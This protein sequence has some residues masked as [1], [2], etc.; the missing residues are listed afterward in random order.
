MLFLRVLGKTLLFIAFLALAYD[1]AR[2]LATPSRGVSLTSLSTH[3]NTYLPGA[4]EGLERFLHGHSA[5]TAW[6]AIAEP[7]LGLPVSIL[8]GALGAVLFLAGY[9]KPP[10]E[11]TG[12]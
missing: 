4:R 9:R 10:P 1:G 5:D 6:T 8:F 7:L 12:D 11:I 3:L 2:I